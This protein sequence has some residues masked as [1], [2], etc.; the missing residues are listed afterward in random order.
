MGSLVKNKEVVTSKA[1]LLL[2]HCQYIIPNIHYANVLHRNK[3][4][5]HC[6][7]NE[8]KQPDDNLL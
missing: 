7:N 8:G 4:N 2:I 5:D 6:I 3:S 1:N